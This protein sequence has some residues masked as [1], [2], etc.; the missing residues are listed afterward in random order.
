MRQ[1]IS[2]IFGLAGFVLLLGE[3]NPFD[4]DFREFFMLKAIGVVCVGFAIIFGYDGRT[5]KESRHHS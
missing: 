2:A 3:E 1:L 4:F 5:E